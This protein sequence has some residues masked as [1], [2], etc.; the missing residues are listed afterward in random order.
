M[1][2]QKLGCSI[3]L[4][5]YRTIE[6]T[7]CF[8]TTYED[9]NWGPIKHMV[10]Y[11]VCSCC[12]KRRVKDTV[13]KDTLTGSRHNGVEYGK[14]YLG[15]GETKTPQQPKPKKTADLIVFQGGKK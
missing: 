10:W 11:Q 5:K 12:G 4:H 7:D 14:V 13:K 1:V 6:M 2:F 15:K 3:G 8:T 9:K